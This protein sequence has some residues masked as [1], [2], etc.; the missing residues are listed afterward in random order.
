MFTSQ[1]LSVKVAIGSPVE[2]SCK[3]Q[4]NA[5]AKDASGRER[6]AATDELR[7][8][9]TGYV[10][11]GYKPDKDATSSVTLTRAE[12]ADSILAALVGAPSASTVKAST[13]KGKSDDTRGGIDPAL[14]GD[15]S[16]GKH[17]AVTA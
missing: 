8:L 4:L 6:D 1:V 12:S 17:D 11:V 3:L 5:T 16:N 15:K 7:R 13:R 9:G 10:K 14:T 2:R